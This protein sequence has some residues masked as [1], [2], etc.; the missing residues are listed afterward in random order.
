VKTITRSVLVGATIAMTIAIGAPGAVAADLSELLEEAQSSTYTATRLTVSVW[1][2]ATQLKRERVEHAA[3]AEMVRTDETWSMV[4]NGRTIRM[5]DVPAGIAFVTEFDPIG[6]DRYTIGEVTEITHMRRTCNL[7]Q[8]MEGETVRAH[9]IVDGR[10][11]A[12]LI[13]YFND[14]SGHTYRTVSL[15]DFSPHRTYEWP[16]SG[17]DVAVEIV[18][19]DDPV[20]VPD[21][22]SGYQ[23][24]EV[25]P[26]PG[27]SEQG[28]YSDGLFSFSLFALDASAVVQGFEEPMVYVAD[29]SIYDMVPSA[30]D[31]RVH[32]ADGDNHFVLVGDLPPD[33]LRAVLGSLPEPDSDGMFRRLWQRLFG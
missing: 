24:V 5:G 15:S 10:T 7:V 25:F 30:E 12:P 23:L 17:S 19:H 26:G 31:I 29:G 27:G 28:F 22:V 32:W 2:D 18:M 4:G 20:V 3:G 21:E 6:T 13:T 16:E 11:G 33:H 14:D 1:G 9:M 8:I